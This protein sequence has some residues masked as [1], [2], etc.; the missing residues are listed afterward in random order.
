[1]TFWIFLYA[2]TALEQ[3]WGLIPFWLKT[4][5]WFT[6]GIHRVRKNF[7]TYR[8]ED[9]PKVLV[10]YLNRY[11][12]DVMKVREDEGNVLVKKVYES[13]NKLNILPDLYKC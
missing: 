6:D 5:P 7:F 2:A 10:R 12:N 4:E 9:N 3:I 8:R 11:F 1:M 13:N